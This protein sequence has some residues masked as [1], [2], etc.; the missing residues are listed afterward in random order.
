MI[1][2]A[3][4]AHADYSGV[5]R[6]SLMEKALAACDELTGFIIAV[7]LVKPGRA[8]AS[9]DVPSVR[10]KCPVDLVDDSAK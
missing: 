3:I 2:R 6:E 10:R 1:T 7:A 5:P 9:V 8:L 4:L